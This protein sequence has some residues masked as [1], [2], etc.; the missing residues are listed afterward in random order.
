MPHDFFDIYDEYRQSNV[1]ANFSV[2]YEEWKRRNHT[3]FPPVYL[4]PSGV[5]PSRCRSA[6]TPARIVRVLLAFGRDRDLASNFCR[7]VRLPLV[8]TLVVRHRVFERG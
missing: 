7:V 3:Y 1:T 8:Y 4:F 2:L 5:F 6:D